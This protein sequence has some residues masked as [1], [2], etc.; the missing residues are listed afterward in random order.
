MQL[1]D[2]NGNDEVEIVIAGEN[3]KVKATDSVKD[4]LKSLLQAKGINSFT[5]LV[6]GEEVTSTESLPSTF[7]DHEVEVER[8]VKPG[9]C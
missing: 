8:Y 9:T 5:I 2:M 7:G 6:D 1:E 3:V 4:T